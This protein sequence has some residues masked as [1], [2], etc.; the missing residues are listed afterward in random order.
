MFITFS[1]VVIAWIFFRAENVGHALSYISGIFSSSLFTIPDFDRIQDALITIMLVIVFM[2]IEWLGREQQHA[3]ANME[4]VLTK[5]VRWASYLALI[6]IIYFFG[7]FSESIEF[8]YFQ[9]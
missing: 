2:M 6:L 1:L 5:P 4:H 9:F 8:I 7:N 3:L